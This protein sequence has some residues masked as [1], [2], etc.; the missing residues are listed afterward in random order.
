M[1]RK[2]YIW[3]LVIISVALA[4]IR[5]VTV[6]YLMEKN[7]YEAKTYYLADHWTVD[8]FTGIVI[9]SLVFFIG[10]AI[11]IGK[12]TRFEFDFKNSSVS[13]ASCM[14]AFITLGA[15]FIYVYSFFG[16]SFVKPKNIGI[17]IGFFAVLSG[18]SFLIYALKVCSN[19]V[20]ATLGL[21]PIMFVAFRL[22]GDF[23]RT[24]ATP[25]AS[26]GGY[27]IAGLVFALLYLYCEG[28]AFVNGGS[29]ALYLAFGYCAVILLS[30]YSVPN[31][32][33]HC[34]GAFTFDYYAAYSAVDLVMAGYIASRMSSVMI[35]TPKKDLA[36]MLENIQG[37]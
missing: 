37:A 14:L 31:L 21:F 23:I 32:I 6:T 25:M 9:A 8:V 34:F 7:I 1:N 19:K 17:L 27:H 30:I 4:A 24:S 16:N 13:G 20:F 35:V 3:V 12:G 33:L 18:I 29:A 2:K 36:R 26:S 22:L 11:K 10:L 28:K 15:V 5:T